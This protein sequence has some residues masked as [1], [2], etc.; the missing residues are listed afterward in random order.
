MAADD[1]RELQ[2]RNLLK[3]GD[4]TGDYSAAALF[5][6]TLGEYG[7]FS[8][9][10]KYP[11]PKDAGRAAVIKLL[12]PDPERA[13]REVRGIISAA[14]NPWN[15]Y[16]YIKILLSL[17]MT[18][19]ALDTAWK[20][21]R[22]DISYSN[23]FGVII[24]YLAL[25]GDEK[26]AY[27]T[28]K[29]VLEADPSSAD[30]KDMSDKF[31]RGEKPLPGLYLKAAPELFNVDY[32]IPVY[33][34]ERYMRSS[35]EGILGQDYPVGRLLIIND[36]TKDRSIDIAREYPVD[37]YEHETNMGLSAARN[38]AFLR[39]KADFLG[40][41]DTDAS[42]SRD[43]T[44][45]AMSEFENCGR[46]LSGAGGRMTENFTAAAADKWRAVHMAQQKGERRIYNTDFLFGS[47]CIY[48]KKAV[49][50]AGGFDEKYRTNYEDVDMCR[51]LKK[52]GASIV[53]LPYARAVHFRT[54]DD[55]SVLK[56][57]WNWN[58]WSYEEQGCYADIKKLAGKMLQQAQIS[59]IYINSD[60]AVNNRDLLFLDVMNIIYGCILDMTRAQ[61]LKLVPPKDAAAAKREFI[62]ILKMLDIK[63]GGR[64]LDKAMP[65]LKNSLK[66]MPDGGET[67]AEIKAAADA[68][69]KL[70]ATIGKPLY[71]V[72]AA[73]P[74]G[75]ARDGAA[76]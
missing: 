70:F 60:A 28:A 47:N 27:R 39:S 38:T 66:E 67:P 30:L 22:S 53:Y 21:L 63:Y 45:I 56:T 71:D 62:S 64:L 32:Y 9:L 73:Q 65:I 36:G 74:A 16:T 24:K 25:S 46:N 33:N 49:L 57:R 15:N 68:V 58:F 75:A 48:K 6:A 72:L 41:F 61:E 40:A 55:E 50:D 59:A 37:I 4:E 8:G 52:T 19:E 3:T 31:G 7:K 35:I 43:F 51:R 44:R 54:D 34:V 20:A 13:A 2:E 76:V 42:P 10:E 14:A 11:A 69:T 12:Q 23:A 17:G 1:I 5:F 29:A 26:A 18:S